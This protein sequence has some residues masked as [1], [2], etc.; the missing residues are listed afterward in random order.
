MTDVLT[1]AKRSEVMSRIRG[2]DTKTEPHPS[3]AQ[4]SLDPP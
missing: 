3:P 4:T 1:P 2:R